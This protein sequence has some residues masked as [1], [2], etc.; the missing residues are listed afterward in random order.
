ML[1]NRKLMCE[2]CH[3][4]YISLTVSVSVAIFD[5]LYIDTFFIIPPTPFLAYY[6]KFTLKLDYDTMKYNN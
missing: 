4:H 6:H 3:H 2:E 1:V 5:T